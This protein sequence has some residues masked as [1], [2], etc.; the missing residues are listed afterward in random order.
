MARGKTAK[1]P[2]LIG[3][4]IRRVE[5]ERLLTGH[6]N[7]LDDLNLPGQAHA[8]IVRSPHAHARVRGIDAKAARARPGVLGV[9]TCADM[10][11]DGVKPLPPMTRDPRYEFKNRDGSRMP[12]PEHWALARDKVRYAG[13]C[14]ALVVAETAEIA[15]EAGALVEVDYEILGAVPNAAAALA[16]GAPRVWDELKNNTCFEWEVGDKGAADDAFKRAAHV[17]RLELANERLVVAYMEP[18]AALAAYDETTKSLTLHAS[19][20]GAHRFRETLAYTLDVPQDSVRVIVGDVGGGFGPRGYFYPENLIVAWAARHL[21]RPVKWLGDRGESFLTDVQARGHTLRCALALDKDGRF[22]GLKVSSDWNLGAYIA[23]RGIMATIAH[24]GPIITGAYRFGAVH[25]ELRGVFTN[26][27]IAYAYRGIGRAEA[28]HAL[29]RLVDEAARETGR[30]RIAL[31]RLNM[32]PSSAMPY[33]TQGGAVY[34]SGEFEKNMDLALQAAD[35]KGF[36]ARKSQSEKRGRLRGIGLCNFVENAG[37]AP[38]EFA[39]VKVEPTGRVMLYGGSGP[40]GQGHETAFAQVLADELGLPF[41]DVKVVIGDTAQVRAGYGSAASRSMRKSGT[42][43]V[44]SARA[45]VEK[46]RTL[47]GEILEAAVRD[48]EYADGRFRIAGTDKSVGIYDVAAHAAA[49]GD[50]LSAHGD[51]HQPDQTFPNGCQIAEVEIDPTTGQV[52]LLR[53]TLVNDVGRVI[54]PLILGGQLHGGIAQGVGQAL[55]EQCAYD[56]TSGQLLSGSFMD[57]AIP[58]A[59]EMPSFTIEI[60]EVPCANNPLGVKGAG[61]GGTTGAPPAVV[62]AIVDALAPYGVR[63]IDMPATPERVWHAMAKAKRARRM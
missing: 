13:D 38:S 41:E 26:T 42:A 28:S 1:R 62:N 61:E 20:Q 16:K 36:S 57:Y 30:D 25:F 46:G 3:Q 5:D 27:A 34:D 10:D 11:K 44:L 12:E 63:D 22:T 52:A 32:I 33:A 8:H 15:A 58:R 4:P 50:E 55:I 35:W 56:R 14:V 39:E 48:I 6:G 47:A 49:R 54:N 59:D 18:R 29:E 37:G 9:F 24:M 31:R 21:R 7:Y 60:N 23:A 17:T 40:S 51:H 2:S 19:C 43:T 45:M 53:H